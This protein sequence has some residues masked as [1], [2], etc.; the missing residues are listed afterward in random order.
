MKS[1]LQVVVEEID[2]QAERLLAYLREYE[3]I[4]GMKFQRL[5]PELLERLADRE[6]AVQEGNR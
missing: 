4:T 1:R 5:S 6:S 2:K 3:A